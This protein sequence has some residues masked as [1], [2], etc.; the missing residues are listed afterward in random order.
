M[1][2]LKHV[3]RLLL[4]AI[5]LKIII[6]YSFQRIILKLELAIVGENKIFQEE[7]S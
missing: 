7:H 1:F 3:S 5:A 6:W 2:F 4:F